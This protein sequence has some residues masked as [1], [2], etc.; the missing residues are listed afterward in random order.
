MPLVGGEPQ[1]LPASGDIGLSGITAGGLFPS[2]LT[3]YFKS[4]P[5][6]FPFFKCTLRLPLITVITGP[7]R[8][9]TARFGAFHR[10]GKVPT[11]IFLYANFWGPTLGTAKPFHTG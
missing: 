6:V 11:E 7:R 3:F 8:P 9:L 2:Q 4:E 1:D 5:E 10:Q